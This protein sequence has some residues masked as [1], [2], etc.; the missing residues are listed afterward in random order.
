MATSRTRARCNGLAVGFIAAAGTALL[1][2]PHAVAE[3]Q[4]D[5]RAAIAEVEEQISSGAADRG[6]ADTGLGAESGELTT[7]GAGFEREFGNGAVTYDEVMYGK[8]TGAWTSSPDATWAGELSDVSMPAMP[9]P[10]VH[11]TAA[12]SASDSDTDGSSWWWLLIPFLLLLVGL[13][14]IWLFRKARGPADGPDVSAEAEPVEAATESPSL[15]RGA[16][17]TTAVAAAAG[18]TAAAGVA[19]TD[20]REGATSKGD[21]EGTTADS[22]EEPDV[23]EA[24]VGEPTVGKATVGEPDVDEA[25]V[26][27]PTVE[28]PTVEEP[29]V[30]ESPETTSAEPAPDGGDTPRV[31]HGSGDG[32]GYYIANGRHEPVPVGAHLPLGDPKQAPDGYPIKVSAADGVYYTPDHPSYADLDPEV[33]FASAS[34]AESAGFSEAASD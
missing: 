24:A 8:S 34:A 4:S 21:V 23:D 1:L 11:A 16:P 17:T 33:W 22:T 12:A 20:H 26:E 30:E 13:F 2:A 28:E 15:D 32:V 9:D 27:E 6:Q 14:L 3:P 5:A 25:A 31:T 29:T 19:I 18:G 7:V 10:D